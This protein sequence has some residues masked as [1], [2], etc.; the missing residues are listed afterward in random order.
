MSITMKD[1]RAM[2]ADGVDFGA[3]LKSFAAL[4]FKSD[5]PAD[6]QL[7]EL[8]ARVEERHARLLE[9]SAWITRKMTEVTNRLKDKTILGYAGISSTGELQSTGPRYDVA[10]ALYV[11]AYERLNEALRVLERIERTVEYNAAFSQLTENERQILVQLGGGDATVNQLAKEMKVVSS[12]VEP[13]VE[14]LI[15]RHFVHRINKYVRRN[16]E[17]QWQDAT[18]RAEIDALDV[19]PISN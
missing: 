11:E 18:R 17:Q 16:S 4:R 19:H 9:E 2:V 1:V 8:A 14:Q 12:W 3:V 5:D 13:V 15:A 10:C 7:G 6:Q